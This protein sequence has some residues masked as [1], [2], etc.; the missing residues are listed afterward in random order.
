M[1][2]D[3]KFGNEL[4]SPHHLLYTATIY[5]I[6]QITHI[7]NILGL[8]M[9]CN[10]VFALLSLIVLFR[11]LNL[12][13]T[14]GVKNLLLIAAVAFSFGFWRFATENETYI[15]PIFFSLLGSFYFIKA[16][17]EG[18]SSSKYILLSGLF[19]TIACLYHQIHIFWL[20]GLFFGWIFIDNS[21]SFKRGL[22]FAASFLIAPLCYFL[23]IIFYL[24]QNLNWYNITHFV[25]HDYYI[26]AAGNHF[27][28]NNIF[29][30]GINFIRTFFQVHGQMWVIVSMHSL[31]LL[32]GILALGLILFAI[33]QIFRRVDLTTFKKL[34]NLH[35][36]AQVHILIF[37]LQLAFAI[38][39][40]GN[41]EFMVMLPVLGAVIIANS[42]LM[43]SK[44]LIY[45]SLSLL[46]W[47]FTYGIFPNN[48]F[49]F[50]A[51][52]KVTQFIIDHPN[53][54]FVVAEPAIVFNQYYYQKGHWPDN[55]WAG[56]GY[57]ELHGTLEEL[58]YKI[59][60]A[61]SKCNVYTDCTGIP[62]VTSRETMTYQSGMFW[63]M[64]YPNQDIV[65]VFN[66]D[67]EAHEIFKIKQNSIHNQKVF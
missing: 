38:Y 7:Q 14:N 13:S 2:A 28:L 53:D 18:N 16:F 46:I 45:F 11:I 57:Y 48:H 52:D 17:K 20:I 21:L 22:V 19:A 27:G 49:H 24:H 41:A 36:I 4:F 66:T 5:V 62:K 67:G 1:A 47:N 31:W 35:I 15:T 55:C 43:P 30:G 9:F 61:L 32:P 3:V 65:A 40:I 60:S 37:L 8:G 29:L 44:S 25:F 12:L 54:K 63:I 33:V 56:P 6:E 39:N 34:S 26:G 23:T 64:G 10:A 59:D 58:A 51:N 50:N 42:K